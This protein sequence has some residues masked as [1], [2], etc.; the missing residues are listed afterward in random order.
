MSKRSRLHVIA[1]ASLLC[2]V[3][4]PAAAVTIDFEELPH[5][6]ELAGAGDVYSHKGFTLTYA[7]APGEPYPVGFHIVGPTW[8]FNGRSVA[9]L[10]NSCSGTATLTADD[11]NPLTLKAIDLA[12]LNGDPNT[13]VSVTFVGTTA[14]GGTVTQTV[15]LEGKKVWKRYQLPETFRNLRSVTWAQGDCIVNM[16][17]MYDNIRVKPTWKDKDGLGD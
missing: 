3:C 4:L 2:I 15:A 1:C 13:T 14:E 9:F 6:D 7:P 16:P 17:H 8:R 5:A 10:T 12:A 11:N